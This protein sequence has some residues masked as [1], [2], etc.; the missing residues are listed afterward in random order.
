[1]EYNKILRFYGFNLNYLLNKK[2]QFNGWID[3]VRFLQILIQD[4]KI[5]YCFDIRGHLDF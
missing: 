3:L 5:Y 2:F 1:M 4:K